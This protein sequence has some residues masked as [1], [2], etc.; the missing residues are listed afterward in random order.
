[1]ARWHLIRALV[2]GA[3]ALISVS[4]SAQV[5]QSG[6]VTPQHVPYWVTSGVIADGGTS[7]DS[8]ISSLGVTNNGGNA[9]CAN[10]ARTTAPGWQ[11][12]CLGVSTTGPGIISLQ[13]YGTAS[14]QSLEFLVNGSRGSTDDMLF[15]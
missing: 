9:I 11:S 5:K 3:A 2:A 1:M 13:N 8:P 12:L 4:A 7:A 10:S 14:P 15:P 6:T